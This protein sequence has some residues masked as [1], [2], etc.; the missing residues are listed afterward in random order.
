MK[1]DIVQK[2]MPVLYVSHGNPLSVMDE[3][4]SQRYRA[5]AASLPK[6]KAILIFSAHWE[7]PE[8]LVGET[9]SHEK[10]IYDFYGF[11]D[12][13][14]HLQYPAPG[15]EWLLSEIRRLIDENVP[16]RE[17]GLDHG[18]WVPLLRM[19]PEADVPILQMSLPTHYSNQA[20]YELGEHLRP[21]REKG[22][23]IIGGGT[24]THNLKE[25]LSGRYNKTPD[26][27]KSFDSWVA[28][29]LQGDRK[30][31]IEWE[32]NAPDPQRNHPTAEHFR[33]LLIVAGAATSD[34]S[35]TFPLLGFDMA[36]FSKRCVQFG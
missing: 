17:R 24:L 12:D 28:Q 16:Q 8:L 30:Q 35:L 9:V 5:W 22:V 27:I 11:P 6:P 7:D 29:T 3:K 33:P 13:L 4:M 31:L 21:L 1:T 19:W 36:A 18:V 34:D 26:W 32:K 23:M 25:G 2:I 10:L 14:Y 20:L 15:A